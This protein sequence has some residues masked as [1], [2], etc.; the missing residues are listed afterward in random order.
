LA[1]AAGELK[2][3]KSMTITG[4]SA[5]LLKIDAGNGTDNLF[6]TGDGFRIFNVDDS[7]A[8]TDSPVTLLG[9]TLT[10]AT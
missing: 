9:L 7:A 4:P 2:L 8:G 6:N 1:D 10:G 5:S 3:L